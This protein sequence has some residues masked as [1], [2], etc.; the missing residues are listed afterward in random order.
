MNTITDLQAHFLRAFGALEDDTE[1]SRPQT[2]PNKLITAVSSYTRPLQCRWGF[3]NSRACDSFHLGEMI[4]FFAMRSKTIFLGSTLIDP[5]YEDDLDEEQ[6]EEEE[7]DHDAPIIIE[8]GK[9]TQNDEVQDRTANVT[10]ADI[11]SIT[12]SLRQIPDYQI[13]LNHTGCGIRRRLLPVLDCVE[14]FIGHRRALIGLTDVMSWKSGT[15]SGTQRRSNLDSWKSAG[16][17][18]AEEVDVRGAKIVGIRKISSKSI[19]SAIN[20]S[21]ASTLEHNGK[22]VAPHMIPSSSSPSSGSALQ[23]QREEARLFFTAR[24]RNWER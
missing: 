16:L 13:D 22:R 17:S 24:K 9:N 21:K 3:D 19:S 14:G 11:L 6:G 12:A 1:R 2:Q 10:A 8:N 7:D 4:R 20:P 23:Q 15:Y 18:K 5:G